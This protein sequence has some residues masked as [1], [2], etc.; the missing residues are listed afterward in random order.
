MRARLRALRAPSLRVQL[1]G[2]LT[3]VT[4]LSTAIIFVVVYRGT[5][6]RLRSEIDQ[7]VSADA[8]ELA[9]H[10]TFS[11]ARTPQQLLAVGDRYVKTR[12]FK[13]SSTL[14]LVLVPG[15]GTA[16]NQPEVFTRRPPDEGESAA[17]QS[18]EDNLS[19]NLLQAP[20]G[21]STV[22]LQDVGDLRLAKLAVRTP[23]G[24]RRHR[25]R[26][27]VARHR[28]STP[29]AASPARSSSLRCS[30]SAAR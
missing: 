3:I 14:L 16:T 22:P 26:R 2:A 9:R 7:E 24:L 21:Y 29:S 27:R 30:A 6:D 15:A 10:L 20:I 25:R 8:R 28:W 13:A 17:E 12:P 18:E 5:G 1:A 4:L 19:A 23:H 11:G